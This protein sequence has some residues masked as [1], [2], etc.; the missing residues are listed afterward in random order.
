MNYNTHTLKNGLRVVLAPMPGTETATVVIMTGTGSRYEDERENGLAH[1]LE[2]MF[3]KGTKKRP[4]AKAIS[5]ELDGVGAVYNAFTSKDRTA[6]Y[7]KVGAQYVEVALDVITDI[8]LNSTLPEKE[9]NKERGAVI[10]EIDM[11]EDIPMRIVDNVFEELLF[12]KDHPLGR[13]ILGPKE[14]IRAF[15]RKDFVT[16]RKKHYNAASSVVCVAGNFDEKK[17]L[18]KIQKVFGKLPKASVSKPMLFADAQRGARVA[19]KQKSTDQ[20]QLMLGLPAYPYLHKDE[21]ALA[22]LST[23]LG[24]SMSSRLFTEVREKRG[25]AYSVQSWIEKYPDTGYFAV[26]AG[27]E[28]GKLEKAIE[29]IIAEFRKVKVKKVSAAE[30]KKAKA[31][32]KGTTTLSLETSDE[33]AQNALTSLLEIGRIRSLEERLQLI[34]KVTAEDLQRV[35]KDIFKSEKLNLA[36]IGPHPDEHKFVPLLRI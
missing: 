1:F 10:Q 35:A 21:Y 8:F 33:V 17:T 34:D 24:G 3:F 27:V 13:T 16:Y 5:E 11:Y 26:Q 12:G 31:Y 28:H 9:I 20:T 2:H 23:L 4:S 19:I 25:L 30:L 22:V 6:Y 7:A 18:E 32:L 14:N 15:S 36:I 29:T